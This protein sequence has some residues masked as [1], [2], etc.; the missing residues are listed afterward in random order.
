VSR[1]EME[2]FI[3]LKVPKP[4]RDKLEAYCK[5]HGYN[6]SYVIRKAVED[7]I[8]TPKFTWEDFMAW[9]DWVQKNI[10]ELYKEVTELL[11][12]HNNMLNCLGK[13]AT[14][15]ELL[16]SNNKIFRLLELLTQ[17]LEKQDT[18]I[19][20]LFG[21]LEKMTG[22]PIRQILNEELEKRKAEKKET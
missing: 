4:F 12:M 1:Q 11:K 19:R 2:E 6:I 22:Q 9:K 21:V 13:L 15:Q 20:V 16:D 5:T 8:L 17:A 10:D 7:Q 14:K 3:G 18:Q